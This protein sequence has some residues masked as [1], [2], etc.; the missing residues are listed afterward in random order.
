MQNSN[1]ITAVFSC[2]SSCLRWS[3]SLR[4][5]CRTW[6]FSAQICS[7]R[8]SSSSLFLHSL[9]FAALLCCQAG[10]T[11]AEMHFVGDHK[12]CSKSLLPP[13]DGAKSGT[14]NRRLFSTAERVKLPQL[15]FLRLA[16]VVWRRYK[17]DF[18]R[19]PIHHTSAHLKALAFAFTSS[20]KHSSF[21]FRYRTAV[22]STRLAGFSSWKWTGSKMID[23]QLNALLSIRK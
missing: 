1:L 7:L 10:Q 2:C 16:I 6:S 12:N 19:D 22:W 15:A 18:C 5:S 14:Q 9:T 3:I 23:T 4:N 20:V 11:R 8:S 21:S 13:G 17:Q